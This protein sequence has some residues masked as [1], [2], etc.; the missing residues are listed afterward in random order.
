MTEQQTKENKANPMRK[1]K[2]DKVT[3]NIGAGK[4]Q[5]VLDKGLKLIEHITGTKAVQ[6]VTQ[7]RI[8]DW[9]IRPGL[10]IGCK[11]TL[12]G[13]KAI[14]L[15]NI[16]LGGIE[17]RMNEKQFDDKGNVSFGIKE[18]IDIPDVK[19]SPDIPL[20]G[21]SVC[22]S[23]KRAG[24]RIKERRITKRKIGKK[25]MITKEEAISFIKSKFNVK[26]GED[27]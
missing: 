19:Y 13:K 8:P 11:L 18:Y 24:F 17:H 25:H 23:L 10:P 27:E 21:L 1:L 3:L 26:M 14:E 15:L 4:D 6:T 9:G 5:A 16:L 7:K 22:I 20:M 2:I 12:R